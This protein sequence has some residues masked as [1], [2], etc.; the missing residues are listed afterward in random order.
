MVGELG[1]LIASNKD[2]EKQVETVKM[3]EESQSSDDSVR[4]SEL[5][6]SRKR[7]KEANERREKEFETFM[8]ELESFNESSSRIEGEDEF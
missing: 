7:L 4:I 3:K 8:K 1:K 2:Y 5:E 6:E